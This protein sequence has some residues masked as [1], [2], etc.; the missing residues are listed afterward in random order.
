MCVFTHFLR[1]F[2]N[3]FV[4][5]QDVFRTLYVSCLPCGRGI[6][7]IK[8]RNKNHQD[9]DCRRIRFRREPNRLTTDARNRQH[10]GQ[11]HYII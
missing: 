8:R 7:Y 4:S 9:G 2:K 11:R 6:V 3:A 1:C 5:L 10:D